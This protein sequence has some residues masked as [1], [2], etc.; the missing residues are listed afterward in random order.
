MGY[1]ANIARE[2]D[3]FIGE[4]GRLALPARTVNLPGCGA[5]A[6]VGSAPQPA[7][8]AVHD[9]IFEINKSALVV[10]LRKVL[11]RNIETEIDRAAVADRD[12]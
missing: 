9:M 1:N 11:A 3:R 12:L 2:L 6:C 4:I 10:D 7:R 5:V 8:G